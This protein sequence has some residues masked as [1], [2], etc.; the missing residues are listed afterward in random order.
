MTVYWRDLFMFGTIVGDIAGSRFEFESERDAEELAET[1]TAVTHDREDAV[2]IAVSLGGDSDAIASADEEWFT[3]ITK[4]T[5]K[6]SAAD[7]PDE[8]V[9]ALKA[10]LSMLVL[11][12]DE[13]LYVDCR[14]IEMLYMLSVGGLEYKAY[15][16]ECAILRL[17]RKV[18]LIQA[19]KNRQEKCA[20]S[21]IEKLLDFEFAEYQARLNEQVEKMNAALERSRCEILSDEESRELKKLYRAVVKAL[22]PDLHPDLSEAKVQLFYNAVTAYKN[23]DLNGLRIVAAMIGGLAP[24]EKEQ[25]A[26]SRL[27]EERERL[28]TLIQSVKDRIA[29]IKSEYPYTMK[30]LVQSPEKTE[31]RK[32]ELEADIER[33][34]ETLAAYTAKIEEMLR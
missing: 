21:E 33:L 7:S 2:R 5:G 30:S 15:E 10:E 11:E 28:S 12:R 6:I 17:K 31:A 18:E 29:E 14:N 22:H 8:L 16:I 9:A 32:A 26:A 20:L 4:D 24:P 1:V 27:A 25:D 34:N 19:K 23:G 13:L 3:M